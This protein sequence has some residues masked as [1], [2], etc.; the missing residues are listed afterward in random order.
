MKTSETDA[1]PIGPSGHV[2][3]PLGSR[4]WSVLTLGDR[5]DRRT[6]VVV[7]LT[8]AIGVGLFAGWNWVVA[9]GLTSLVL[10]ILPCAAMCAL[11]LCGGST[12]KKC[13]EPRPGR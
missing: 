7:W 5:L 10:G 2:A 11:G 6:A 4:V 9:A 8:A 3:R 13:S 1:N 12:G